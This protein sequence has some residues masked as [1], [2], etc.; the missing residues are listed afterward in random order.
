MDIK[1]SSDDEDERTGDNTMFGKFDEAIVVR[2]AEEI[3]SPVSRGLAS[4]RK[5]RKSTTS[6]S[7]NTLASSS[8]R[9]SKHEFRRRSSDVG[10][11]KSIGIGS[12]P[13]DSEESDDD[14]IQGTSVAKAIDLYDPKEFENLDTSMEVKELFQNIQRYTPQ[15][16]ELNYKLMPFVPDYI[17]AVGDIDAFIKVPRPDGVEDKI[18]L[19][20]LDEPCTN[21][22]DPAVLHL[23]LRNHSR[24]AGAAVRQAVVK[25]IEDAEKNSKSID[26][27]ID[28]MNQL[29]RSKHLP[30]VHMNCAMPDID[31]LMQQWPPQVEDKLNE[32]QLN[33]S[34]L[35]CELPQL[36]DVV[37]NLLDIPTRENTRLEALHT[38]FTLYLEI[39]N[40]ENRNFS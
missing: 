3:K 16:I 24:S 31:G 37:C 5:T 15:R 34:E 35:D 19:T 27:W 26:K 18:G 8:P 39:R 30:G 1:D 2:N 11:E 22:S 7:T 14:D 21:Q 9:G 29:H 23:Q 38:L 32:L 20:V 25:R 17:P 28:D 40:V 6:D 10:F 13:S 12:D 33:L 4:S 36:V